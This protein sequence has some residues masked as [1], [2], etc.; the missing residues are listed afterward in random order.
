MFRAHV[1]IRPMRAQLRVL[2]NQLAAEADVCN[3]LAPSSGNA[4]QYDVL[5]GRREVQ[6]IQS[7]DAPVSHCRL[8]FCSTASNGMRSLLLLLLLLLP[9]PT[10]RSLGARS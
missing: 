3:A 4:S 2:P 9:P 6:H 7:D 1:H 8:M 5:A 10:A